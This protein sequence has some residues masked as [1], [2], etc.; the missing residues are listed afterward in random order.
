MLIHFLASADIFEEQPFSVHLYLEWYLLECAGQYIRAVSGQLRPGS[1]KDGPHSH[2][3]QPLLQVEHFDQRRHS[4]SSLFLFFL[5]CL[6]ERDQRGVA[7]PPLTVETETNGDSW[8]TYKRGPSLVGSLGL[9]CRYKRFLS[10]VHLWK[11]K[12]KFSSYGIRKFRRDPLQSHYWL[13][14]YSHKV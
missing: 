2:C 3:P 12:I 7:P 9:L 10:C 6:T 8:S 14:A 4:E 5:H 13:T 11:I 1:Q